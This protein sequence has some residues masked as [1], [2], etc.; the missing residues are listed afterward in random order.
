MPLPLQQQFVV[1][2][3]YFYYILLSKMKLNIMCFY[4]CFYG[5]VH[6]TIIFRYSFFDRFPFNELQIS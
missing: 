2:E 4:L 6:M 5:Y 1:K 3:L